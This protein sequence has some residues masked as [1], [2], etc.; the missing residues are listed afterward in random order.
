M[1]NRSFAL[2]ILPVLMFASTSAEVVINELMF[3]PPSAPNTPEPIGEEFIELHNTD[4]VSAVSLDGW[5]LNAGVGFS[6]SGTIIPPGGFVVVSADPTAFMAKYP[7]VPAA[8]VGPWTGKLSNS[9]ERVRLV[10]AAGN[11]VDELKYSDEGDWAVRRRGPLDSGHRGWIWFNE[12]DG[13]GA[14]MELMN[15]SLTNKQGQNWRPTGV[16]GETPGEMN[17]SA[18]GDIAPM[19]REVEHRPAVPTSSDFVK[20]TAKLTDESTF[21]L[22]A[23]VYFRA[24]TMSPG[25]FSS[26]PMVDN[27]LEGDGDAG[28]GV[29]GVTLPSFPDGTVVEFYVEASDGGNSRTWPGP[30]N[31]SGDHGANALYQVE[32]GPRTSDQGLPVYRLIMTAG[33]EDEFAFDN[34]DWDSNAQMNTTFIAQVGDDTDVRYLAGTRRR[35]AGSRKRDPRTMRLSLPGDRPWQ[36]TTRMNLNSQYNYLQMFGQ[37]LFA[38]SRLPSALAR[39]VEL[40][41]NGVDESDGTQVLYGAY[42]HMEPQ[43]SDSVARQFP[44]DDGGNLYRKRRPDSQLAFRNGD[45]D[46]YLADGWE[47]STND[48]EADWSDLDAWLEALNET[49]NPD[50]LA[51]LEATMDIDQWLRWFAAMALL[52]NGET[53]PSTGV[54]DDYY[55]YSGDLD[56]RMKAVPHDLD[57]ILGLGDSSVINDPQH[58]IYDMIEDDSVLDVLVPLIRH[59]EVLPRYHRVLR[60]LIEGPFSKEAFDSLLNHCLGTRI[61]SATKNGI[62]NFMDAR[63]AYVLSVVNPDLTISTTLPVVGGLPQATEPS[64]TFSGAVNLSEAESVRV[65]GRLADVDLEDGTWTIGVA[66]PIEVPVVSAGA[67][68][69]YL[70]DGSDQG[71]AWRGVAFDD[72]GW[73]TG[74]AEFGYGDGD[75]TTVVLF[76]PN[77]DNAQNDEN[78]KYVTTYF[79]KVVNIANPTAYDDFL[80]KLKRDDGAAVFINGTRYVLDN[81]ADGASYDTFADVAVAPA[82]EAVFHEFVIPTSA[83]VPGDNTIAV[84]VHQLSLDNPDVSFDFALSGLE[85]PLGGTDLLKPGINQVLVEALDANGQVIETTTMEV[86]YDDGDTVNFSG[87]LSSDVTLTAADGPYVIDADI[88]VPS[89]LTLTIEAG[90]SLFFA[91]DTRLTVQGRLVAEGLPHCRVQFTVFPGSGDTWDGVYFS[92][93][94]EDNR[95]VDLDQKFSTAASHSIGIN[96]ARLWLER[97]KWRGTTETVLEV[98][99]PQLNVI[100]CDFPSSS[101]NEV[102]HGANLSGSDYFNLIGN[103]FQTSSGYNDIIDFSGGRRPGP[104]IYVINNRFLGGTDDC[105]DLDGIDAHIEGNLFSNIHTDDPARPSTSNAIATDGDAHITIVRNIFDDVDHALLLKNE[106]DAL[107]ENNIVRNATLGAISFREILRPS[108]MAGSDVLCRGNIFIDNAKTFADPDHLRSVGGTPVITADN[109]IMPAEDHIYGTGNI[110][111]DPAFV[112]PDGGDWSLLPGSPAI[113]TGINGQDMGAMIPRGAWVSGEPPALTDQTEATLIPY[114]PGITGIESGTFVTEYRWRLDGGPWSADIDITVPISLSGLSEG[115]HQVEVLGKD[116]A[117]RWQTTPNSSEVWT[118]TATLPGSVRINEVLA[119]RSDGPDWVELHNPGSLDLDIGGYL[120]TDDPTGLG[121][122]VI[123]VATNLPAGGFVRFEVDPLVTF[124]LDRDGEGVYLFHGASLLDSVTFGNQ[125]TDLSL[126]RVGRDGHWALGVPTPLAE[127]VPVGTGDVRLLKINEWVSNSEVVIGNDFVELYNPGSSPVAI[128]GLFLTDNPG[129]EIRQ[130]EIPALSFIDGGGFLALDFSMNAASRNVGL[131]DHGL[132]EIDLV[133]FTSQI[134]DTSYVRVPDGSSMIQLALLPT[135]GTSNGSEGGT[136]T[137]KDFNLVDFDHTWKYEDSGTDL[138]T[139]W[140]APGFDD[141]GWS[142]GPGLIGYETGSLPAPGLQTTLT[143]PQANSPF[144]PTYYFRTEF[145]YNGDLSSTTLAISALIDDGVAVYLNGEEVYLE[146]LDSDPTYDDF[147]NSAEETTLTGPVLIPS[148][149][150]INGV[151]V[152]AAEVHQGNSGSSDFVFGLKLD[153]TESIFTPADDEDYL[154]ALELVN[155]LRITE[156]MFD[157]AE[158]TD[159]EF[160]ELQNIGTEPL[161]LEGVRFVEGIQFVFPQMTLAPGAFVILVHNQVAFENKY[162]AG[163]HPVVGQYAGKLSNGGEELILRLPEPY[164]ANIQKFTYNDS[165]Y[166]VADGGGASLEII[167]PLGRVRDWNNRTAW[168]AGA[169]NGT[170][171]SQTSLSAGNIQVMVLPNSA[172]LNGSVSGWSPSLSWIMVGGPAPVTINSPSSED[173]SVDFVLPGTYRFQLHGSD[174]ATTLIGETTVTVDD[175]YLQ[176]AM[177]Q[178]VLSAPED[179]DDHDGLSNLIEY[180]AELDPNVANVGPVYALTGGFLEYTRYLRKS[181]IVYELEESSGLGL[182]T[183]VSGDLVSATPDTEQYRFQLPTGPRGFVRMKI[184]R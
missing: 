95:M 9:G 19:I 159:Y 75:E 137:V 131:Y 184:I 70:D 161:E 139:A 166:P 129:G 179:D 103:V 2:T 71:V 3:H 54:D 93:T 5:A 29:F 176:W 109:N 20:I 136:T 94:P 43:G 28:D 30:T 40:F 174:G 135:P 157:P 182:W 130:L 118:V 58:T 167:D 36:D 181:D 74:D 61:P 22:T 132:N 26:L 78:N 50:Y 77:P 151:N 42:V 72:S 98:S 56:Q 81:L 15:P 76:G 34:F 23:T 10:D 120:L 116:S 59:P 6:F 47:K 18:T 84:E 53:N 89:G 105:L 37:K 13:E 39:P 162:G 57:T 170:P 48:S 155:N 140:R 169:L 67:S 17:S 128:G 108:V 41:M 82:E 87:T 134:E 100:D 51:N 35:G 168:R 115:A 46:D 126:A 60:E 12:A 113:G 178:G 158:G 16:G 62:V 86:W 175:T 65:N 142:S 101:G 80:I 133:A 4:P 11:E 14:S 97:V 69:K 96:D 102:I 123:P 107:F 145:T 119:D 152:L 127:N 125:L 121:G 112:D 55:V 141:S 88:V 110:E 106:S 73:K 33:E 156:V 66:G 150:L 7:D 138:G 63:R 21:G 45:I 183:G 24:A 165:W 153:A 52:A 143:D 164:G 91:Q 104:I 85:P 163:I 49:T 8:V 147:A 177:R 64:P 38:A 44:D 148:I 117:G 122:L 90:T 27:A 144:I 149:D 114:M 171:G 180:A 1:K 99:G 173:T 68:W 160:I 172:T 154:A 79:R 83:F 92:G 111:A 32:D 31:D 25:A 146:E 124:G